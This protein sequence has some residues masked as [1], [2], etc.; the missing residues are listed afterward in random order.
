M[1]NKITREYLETLTL[2]QLKCVDIKTTEDEKLVQE[3][4]DKLTAGFVKEVKFDTI[5]VPDIKTPEIEAE[6][7]AKVDDFY[8]KQKPLEVQ[9]EDAKIELA[10]LTEFVSENTQDKVETIQTPEASI[11][12]V[13]VVKDDKMIVPSSTSVETSTKAKKI[14]KNKIKN[15]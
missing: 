9:I 6:W 10:S 4:I 11:S 8:N 14:N 7:Q 15:D 13:E 12:L 2:K 3:F 1:T 5:K